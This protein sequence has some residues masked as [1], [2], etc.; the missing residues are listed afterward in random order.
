MTDTVVAA[1]P[2]SATPAGAS[3]EALLKQAV[4]GSAKTQ[5]DAPPVVTA[6]RALRRKTFGF[7][8]ARAAAVG[9]AALSIGLILG[10]G[11]TALTIP[12]DATAPLTLSAIKTDLEAGR[13]E[14]ARIATQIGR[15]AATV[16][17]SGERAAEDAKAIRAEVS[18]R[19]AR[20]EQAIAARLVALTDKQDVS[21]REQAARI[22]SLGAVIDK[23]LAVPAAPAPQPVAP[24]AAKAAPAEP[25]QTGSLADP[26]GAVETKPKTAAVTNWAVREVYDGIAVLED[27]KRRLVEVARGDMVP[28]VG[29]V[30][31]IERR[32][33]AWAVVTKDGVIT[34]QDW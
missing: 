23:R 14:T 6:A 26:K 33:R 8:D 10:A 13:S 19:I 29:R 24:Q 20:M 11:G 32:G 25:V 4:S 22:A 28:G 1:K 27:R 17:Q 2:P 3:A 30:E 5:P 15:L 9:G 12:R 34:A 18:Q 16:G 7:V 31:T 21:D